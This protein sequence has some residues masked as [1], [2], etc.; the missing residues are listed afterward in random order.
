MIQ[1]E[2]KDFSRDISTKALLN[3]NRTALAE[4]KF[5]LEQMRMMQSMWADIEMLKFEFEEIKKIFE[6]YKVKND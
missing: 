3:T 2:N 5:R 4:H 6:N 1:T